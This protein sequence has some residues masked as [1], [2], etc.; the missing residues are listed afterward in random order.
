M[1]EGQKNL[2]EAQQKEQAQLSNSLHHGH[3]APTNS[4]QRDENEVNKRSS[5][6]DSFSKDDRDSPILNL[7]SKIDNNSDLSAED[8]VYVSDNDDDLASNEDNKPNKDKDSDKSEDK[9]NNN[10]TSATVSPNF[11]DFILVP[12]LSKSINS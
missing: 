3:Q 4:A 7:S 6:S 10:G 5:S 11:A 12:N 2:A 9:V 8:D 1:R